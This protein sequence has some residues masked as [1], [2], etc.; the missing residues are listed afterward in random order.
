MNDC[1]PGCALTLFTYWHLSLQTLAGSGLDQR[2]RE[3]AD[4]NH[5]EHQDGPEIDR[6]GSRRAFL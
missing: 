3:V 4:R 5:G 6:D 2:D 1:R